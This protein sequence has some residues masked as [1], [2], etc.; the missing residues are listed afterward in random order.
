MATLSAAA[1][2]GQLNAALAVAGMADPVASAAVS[3]GRASFSA[4]MLV[5]L[6]ALLA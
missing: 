5:A 1:S 2:N 6:A 4:V 3:A